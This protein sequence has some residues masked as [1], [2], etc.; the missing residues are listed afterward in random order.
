MGFLLSE[1][2]QVSTDFPA[3]SIPA[4]VSAFLC[5]RSGPKSPNQP[6]PNQKSVVALRYDIMKFI[7]FVIFSQ[8]RN[9]RSDE[10]GRCWVWGNERLGAPPAVV[11]R[12][13]FS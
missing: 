13:C 6:H 3:K 1:R 4:T 2:A 9:K 11:A 5:V 10:L 12:P 8:R 7:A